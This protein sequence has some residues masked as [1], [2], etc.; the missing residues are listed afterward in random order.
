MCVSKD[1]LGVFI[2][3]SSFPFCEPQ[4]GFSYSCK[5]S[6]GLRFHA[7]YVDFI[8]CFFHIGA[9]DGRYFVSVFFFHY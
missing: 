5:M 7:W 4:L 9:T 1:V 8:Q 2:V 3:N 6:A